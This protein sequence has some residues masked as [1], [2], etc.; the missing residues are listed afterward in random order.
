M[1]FMVMVRATDQIETGEPPPSR[2]LAEEMMRY[3]EDLAKAGVLLAADGLLPSSK[4]AARVRF[5]GSRTTVID[6]P[7]T[8]AKELIAG[9]WLIEVSSLAE[10]V[11]WVKR[12]PNTDGTHGEIEIRQVAEPEDLGDAAGPVIEAY[13]GRAWDVRDQPE[14]PEPP[15]S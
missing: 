10:A 9:F 4:G 12:V 3:N 7:F 13:R 5:D 14:P 15:E 1:R 8:E 6:G 2:E 11:E